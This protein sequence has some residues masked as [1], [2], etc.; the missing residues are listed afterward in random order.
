MATRYLIV[1]IF[2]KQNFLEQLGTFV[3]GGKPVEEESLD[4]AYTGAICDNKEIAERLLAAIL[5]ETDKWVGPIKYHEIVPLECVFPDDLSAPLPEYLYVERASMESDKPRLFTPE[6]IQ[7]ISPS[8]I[9]IGLV[10]VRKNVYYHEGFLNAGNSYTA[11]YFN[12]STSTKSEIVSG[13]GAAKTDS[14]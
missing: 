2:Y 10:K 14:S 4:L 1:P 6:R 9:K 11:P 12:S 5:D 8:L 3:F 7:E 13:A